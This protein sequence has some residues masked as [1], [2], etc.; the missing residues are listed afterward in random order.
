MD[1]MTLHSAARRYLMQRDEDLCRQYAT[2]PN[3]GRAED[4]YR[5]SLQA[6][7]IF[8]RYNVVRAILEEVERLDPDQ[9]PDL[10]RVSAAL[11]RAAEE[12]QSAFTQPPIGDVEAEVIGAERRR[13]S[14]AIQAWMSSPGLQTA[15]VAYRRVLASDESA[16]WRIRLEQRWGLQD[17]LWYPMLAGPVPDDVLVLIEASMWEGE[18]VARV[19]QALL[20][21]GSRRVVELREYGADYLVDVDLLAPRYTLAEGVWSDEGMRWIAY[22]CHEGAVAFGGWL[23]DALLRTWPQLERWR[24]SGS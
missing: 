6:K 22:A 5:Y 3:Q 7:R 13:F 12:A 4:G 19:R 10:P 23:A 2:L 18:G 17:M 1:S 20:E 8:P 14:A 9:L 21:L 16:R 24:W 15:P 11:A